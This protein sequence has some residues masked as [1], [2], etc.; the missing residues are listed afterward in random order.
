MRGNDL[1]SIVVDY[2]RAFHVNSNT[3]IDNFVPA[4][5]DTGYF[6]IVTELIRVELELAWGTDRQKS[7]EQ[8]SKRFPN[9]L[10]DQE[11]FDR[12]AFEEYRLRVKAGEIVTP[13]DYETKYGI[14]PYHWPILNDQPISLGDRPVRGPSSDE[15]LEPLE[16]TDRINTQLELSGRLLGFLTAGPATVENSLHRRLR[17]ISL[18]ILFSLVYLSILALSNPVTKV[19]L[20]LGS[21]WLLWF[22]SS[23]L[24]VCLAVCLYLW[25]LQDINLSK[26]RIIEL[27][28]FGSV[29]AELSSRLGPEQYFF[30][31]NHSRG[32]D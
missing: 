28:L 15:L 20:F 12:I 2:E 19:G 10:A 3:E 32:I 16:A 27:G 4:Q 22:N 14:K 11:C 13:H 17:F 29:L 31:P 21:P 18:T 26:L 7:I 30:G 25:I 8:Y 1:D 23:C 6:E 24:I 5:T 9:V